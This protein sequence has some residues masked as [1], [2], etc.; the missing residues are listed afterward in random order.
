MN[1]R[2]GFVEVG[3]VKIFNTTPHPIRVI[4]SKTSL[5]LLEI[6]R[7][8]EPLRIPEICDFCGQVGGIPLFRKSFSGLDLPPVEEDTFFIVALPVAQMF[9]RDDL[10]VPHDLVRDD[11][12]NVIGCRGFAFIG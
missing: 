6:P 12:G 1:R 7:A 4:D 5:V 3:G 9:R 8:T 10:L 2:F 11:D